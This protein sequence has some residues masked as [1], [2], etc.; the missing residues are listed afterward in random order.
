MRNLIIHHGGM[1][2]KEYEDKSANRPG[3]PNLALGQP[4][5]LNGILVT[6][7]LVPVIK[8][9]VDLTKAVDDWLDDELASLG[10]GAGI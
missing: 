2:D 8:C 5:E 10:R 1:C 4:I 6:S 9:C 3:L 7:L